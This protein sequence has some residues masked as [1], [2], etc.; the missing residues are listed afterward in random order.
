MDTV[1]REEQGWG[2]VWLVGEEVVGVS[3]QVSIE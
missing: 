1:C 2:W 3:W